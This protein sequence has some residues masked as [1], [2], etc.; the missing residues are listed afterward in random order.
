[1]YLDKRC[2][3]T[4]VGEVAI[5][6]CRGRASGSP[7]RTAEDDCDCTRL[8]DGRCDTELTATLSGGVPCSCSNNGAVAAAAAMSFVLIE[9]LCV[10]QAGSANAD[11]AADSADALFNVVAAVVVVTCPALACVLRR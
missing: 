9:W 8:P 1:M 4:D 2:L 11:A 10:D 3:A 6:G 7:A 5:D